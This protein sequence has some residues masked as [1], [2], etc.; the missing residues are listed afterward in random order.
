MFK[1]SLSS[2]L[3]IRKDNRRTQSPVST[4]SGYKMTPD[5][6]VPK[7]ERGVPEDS[8]HETMGFLK[9]Y[10]RESDELDR[11]RWGG[12]RVSGTVGLD[13]LVLSE[14]TRSA[15]IWDGESYGQWTPKKNEKDNGVDVYNF[16]TIYNTRILLSTPS[17]FKCDKLLVLLDLNKEIYRVSNFSNY[18]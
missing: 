9:L 14:S 10:F 1:K 15:I 6:E 18:Y 16:I 17:P 11:L 4:K 3:S 13:W 2:S 7:V 8:L 12:Q 5:Q